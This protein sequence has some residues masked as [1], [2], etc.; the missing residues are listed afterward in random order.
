M[1]KIASKILVKKL[2]EV[3]PKLIGANQFAFLGK[4]KMLDGV[5]VVNEV[6]LEANHKKKPTI[7]FKV[8]YEKA[9]DSVQWDFL[10]YMLQQMNFCSK[11]VRWIQGCLESNFVSVLANGSPTGEFKMWKGLSTH[12]PP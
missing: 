9:Y 11:W 2:K 4:R 6:I 8:D 3:L 12:L 1:Y 5:L 7:V 10:L